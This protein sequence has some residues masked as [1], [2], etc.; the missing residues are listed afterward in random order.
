VVVT[1]KLL[2]LGVCGDA[3]DMRLFAKVNPV[4]VKPLTV[5]IVELGCWRPKLP[6]AISSP[7][8][9]VRLSLTLMAENAELAIAQ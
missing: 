6:H 1:V 9:P 8:S 2:Y 7:S 5:R 3:I 4:A